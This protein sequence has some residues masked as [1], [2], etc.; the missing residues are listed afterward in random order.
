[1]LLPL[2]PYSTQSMHAQR[3]GTGPHQDPGI[4]PMM[5]S[6]L[7]FTRCPDPTVSTALSMPEQRTHKT[8][9][10]LKPWT[11]YMQHPSTPW[12]PSPHDRATA[13]P[14]S[15]HY[16]TAHTDVFWLGALPEASSLFQVAHA[17]RASERS[18]PPCLFKSH[19]A[20]KNKCLHCSGREVNIW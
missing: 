10:A 11:I 14:A 19:L 2:Y 15:I 5:L 4:Y 1:M 16:S 6:C 20:A 9:P 12:P 3:P 18:M 7:Y 13:R 8:Q 17:A